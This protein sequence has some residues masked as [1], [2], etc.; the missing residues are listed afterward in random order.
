M[1]IRNSRTVAW[2]PTGVTD[3]IDSTNTGLGSMQALTNLVP[4]PTTKGVFVPRP[5]AVQTAGFSTNLGTVSVFLILGDLVY[6]MIGGTGGNDVPFIYNLLTSAYSTP[7]GVTGSNTP[8]TQPLEGD[9]V[10]ATIEALG[11]YIVVTHPGFTGPANGYIGWF[12]LTTPSAPVWNSG[13]TTVNALANV[14]SSARA[15]LG[16]MYYAVGNALEASDEFLPLQRTNANQVLTLGDSTPITAVKGMG[17]NN[18][19]GGIIE[20]LMS[21]K[22]VQNIYQLT[23]DYTGIPSPW[24]LNTLNVATGTLSPNSVVPTPN[25]LAFAAPDGIRVIDFSGNIGQPIGADGSGVSVPFQ[26]APAPTRIC[27]AYNVQTIRFAVRQ[28]ASDVQNTVE[29]WYNFSLGAWTGP[30]TLPTV[31]IQPWKSTFIA[32]MVPSRGG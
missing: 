19:N 13:T 11:A 27:G 7:S 20:S 6:G 2:R 9:W 21:F 25:G 28:N 24:N 14:P 3:S 10:P 5:A 17:L 31:F 23:G 16:R 26:Q 4:D 12:D 32:A 15:Y 8:T 22:G 30:H 1:P 29:Y 18:V